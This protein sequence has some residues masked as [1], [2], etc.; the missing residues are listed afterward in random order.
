LMA[1]RAGLVLRYS[2]QMEV[3]RQARLSRPSFWDMDLYSVLEGLFF[4][5]CQ[6]RTG[7]RFIRVWFRDLFSSP[8]QLSLFPATGPGGEKKNMVTRAMDRIRERYGDR[9]IGYGRAA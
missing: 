9:A 4:K 6:R 7:V 8:S 5:A 3:A 1:R 2:D